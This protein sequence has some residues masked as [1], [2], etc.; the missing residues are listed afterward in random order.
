[1]AGSFVPTLETIRRTVAIEL[2][3]T[4]KRIGVLAR[5]PGNPVGIASRDLGNGAVALMARGLPVQ[6][7]NAVVGL[8]DG[9]ERSIDELI[10][11]YAEH[12]ARPNFPM[13]PAL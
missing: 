8:Q 12:G 13:V 9:H 1:M 11:W 6:P 5:I 7:F 2:G 10:A 3:Y 4:V